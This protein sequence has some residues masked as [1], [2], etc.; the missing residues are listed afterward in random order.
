MSRVAGLAC[1]LLLLL[2]S[3]ASAATTRVSAPGSTRHANACTKAKPCELEW[4]LAHSAQGDTVQL[5]GG[6]YLWPGGNNHSLALPAGVK[7]RGIV[8]PGRPRI[9]QTAP[10]PSYNGP[11]LDVGS[12]ASVRDV[13]IDQSVGGAGAIDLPANATV[14]RAV[15][16]GENGMYFIGG[17]APRGARGQPRPPF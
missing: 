13:A 9:K 2:P 5:K 17:E 1:S 6:T 8:G 12:R 10:Y 7:L 15:L 3:A 4:A 14:E 16:K 11:L